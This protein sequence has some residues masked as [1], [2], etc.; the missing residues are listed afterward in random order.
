MQTGGAAISGTATGGIGGS[1]G[2][3][4]GGT[5]ASDGGTAGTGAACDVPPQTAPPYSTTFRFSNPGPNPLWLWDNCPLDFDV[6]SCSDQY[7]TPLPIRYPGCGLYDCSWTLGCVYCETCW[8]TPRLVPVGG[9]LDFAWRGQTDTYG[10]TVQ[11]CPCFA[12][13]DVPAGLYRISVP[14]WTTAPYEGDGGPFIRPP[15]ADFTATR[16]FVLD[17]AGAVVVVDLV[18]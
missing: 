7:T 4:T 1:G 16:D 13:H 9:Y 8:A 14:V 10:R 15:P 2:T 17:R 12:P 11:D 18:P 3:L 6:T 5:P